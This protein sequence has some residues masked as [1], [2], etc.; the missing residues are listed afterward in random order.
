MRGLVSSSCHRLAKKKYGQIVQKEIPDCQQSIYQEKNNE[1]E[2]ISRL[3][4]KN[5]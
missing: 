5:T 4:N 3:L 1:A 2:Y